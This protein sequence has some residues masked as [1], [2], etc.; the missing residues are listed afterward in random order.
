MYNA[1]E[2]FLTSASSFVTQI[3]KIDDYLIN[4]GL[5]GDVSNNLRETYITANEKL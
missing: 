4:N 5:D 2:V 1:K 3:I